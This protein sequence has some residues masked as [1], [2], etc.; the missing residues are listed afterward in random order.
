MKISRLYIFAIALFTAVAIGL[1]SCGGGNSSFNKVTVTPADTT[2]ASGSIT[3]IQFTATETLDDNSMTL[4][5]TNLVIWGSEGAVITG[6]NITGLANIAAPPVVGTATMKSTD[7]SNTKLYGTTTFTVK[8]PDSDLIVTPQS[9]L[10]TLPSTLYIAAGT[11]T[12]FYS[13]ATLGS[14]AITQD[15]TAIDQTSAGATW[16]KT[17]WTATS[18]DGISPTVVSGLVTIPA[19][20]TT[21]TVDITATYVYNLTSNATRTR[22]LTIIA[23]PLQS[24]AIDQVSPQNLSLSATPPTLSFTATGTAVDKTTRNYTAAVTWSSSDPTKASIDSTGIATAVA[25]TGGTPVTITAIDPITG[26]S[27][28]STLTVTP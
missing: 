22:K 17:T 11:S 12:Q 1:V 2:V 3:Q 26:I 7:K 8:N 4:N 23:S 18:A 13:L 20:P 10:T 5:M 14:P 28:T 19:S 27:G 25:V 9:A 15:L 24:L 6:V 16:G 21:G